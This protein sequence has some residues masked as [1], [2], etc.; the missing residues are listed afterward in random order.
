MAWDNAEVLETDR[1]TAV[2]ASQLCR[3]PCAMEIVLRDC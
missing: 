1:K 2:T 3:C